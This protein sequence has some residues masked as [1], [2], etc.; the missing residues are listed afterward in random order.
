M[1]K[2]LLEGCLNFG[3]WGVHGYKTDPPK[4]LPWKVVEVTKWLMDDFQDYCTNEE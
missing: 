2:C 4:F 1:V 3:C